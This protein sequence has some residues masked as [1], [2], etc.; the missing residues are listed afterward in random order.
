MNLKELNFKIFWYFFIFFY[1]FEYFDLDFSEL[2]ESVELLAVE[3]LMGLVINFNFFKRS[4]CSKAMLYQST[5]IDFSESKGIFP[6]FLYSFDFF[7]ESFRLSYFR[8]FIYFSARKFHNGHNVI[9]GYRTTN[10]TIT[11]LVLLSKKV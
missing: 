2:Y 7:F 8:I 1:F 10:Y 11:D 4:L 6:T 3:A 9:P 5:F